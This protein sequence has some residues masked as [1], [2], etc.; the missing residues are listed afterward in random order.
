[1]NEGDGGGVEALRVWAGDA[2]RRAALL[3][4][5]E[6]GSRRPASDYDASIDELDRL[7]TL[8]DHDPALRNR[9][10]VLLGSL[11]ALR[12]AA[13]ARTGDKERAERLL[14]AA[15]EPQPGVTLAPQEEQMT[16]MMLAMLAF[17]VADLGP[18]MAGKAPSLAEIS[19][20]ALENPGG[21]DTWMT[22]LRGLVDAPE[23]L[24]SLDPEILR[25]AELFGRVE[26]EG[27]PDD[28]EELMRMVPDGHPMAGQMRELVDMMTL[29]QGDAPPADGRPAP[30]GASVVPP[31]E[32]P[33]DAPAGV[34]AGREPAAGP[35]AAAAGPGIEGPSDIALRALMPTLASMTDAMRSR[36]PHAMDEALGLLR[37]AYER[38]PPGDPLTQMLAGAM[39]GV[40]QLGQAV[41][42]NEQDRERARGLIPE[43]L[44]GLDGNL[45]PWAAP[46][47]VALRIA[48]QT[49]AVQD[50]QG[51]QDVPLLDA[52]I[53]ELTGIEAGLAPG[54]TNLPAAR[55][56]LG[57]ARM[58]R[59]LLTGDD[60]Q[61]LAG[62]DDIGA[63]AAEPELLPPPMRQLAAHLARA[64]R[65]VRAKVTGDPASI[66]ELSD[67]GPDAG[68][69]EWSSHASDLALRHEL[70]SDPVDLDG[71]ID[72]Y[73]RVR[74]ALKEGRAASLAADSLWELT[75]LHQKRWHG[76]RR[77]EDAAA[78]TETGIEAL[79]ALA[80]DVVL[81][82]GPEHGLLTARSGARRGVE[83]AKW[84]A[85]QGQL[86]QAV[87]A[88][89]LGRAT[90]LHAAAASAGV[91]ELLEGRGRPDLAAAWREPVRAGVPDGLPGE[92]PSSLRRQALEVL[93]YR[94]QGLI[95]TPTVSE[96]TAGVTASDA[97][98]LVYLMTGTGISPGLALMVGPDCGTCVIG[99]P[100]LTEHRSGPLVRYMDAAAER[101][102]RPGDQE[103]EQAWEAAL[104]TLCEWS[105]PAALGPVLS[106]MT[107]R[108][109]ANANRRPHSRTPRIVLVPCGN[110]G[111]V[112]WHAARLP[113]VAPADYACQFMAISYAASGAHFL[114][115]VARDRRPPASAAVLLADPRID[116][117]LAEQE[118]V[119]LNT[120]FYPDARLFGEYYDPDLE[121]VADGTPDELMA[122]LDE[123]LSVLHLA[124]HGSA[125]TSPTVSALHLAFPDGTQ[126]LP[127][128]RGGEGA[129]PDLG[130]LTVSRLLERASTAPPGERAEE[131]GPLVVL[132]A[133]ETDFSTRDH[134]EALTLA[135]AFVAGGARDVVGSRW[136]TQ[137]GASALMMA[138]FHHYVAVEGRSPVDAL[139]G[140]QMWM[141]DPDRRDPGTLGGELLREMDR[142][143]LDRLPLWAAFTH[144]GNP[145]PAA[146]TRGGASAARARPAG[147]PAEPEE[148][149]L[150][151]VAEHL[152]G[153][154]AALDD[155][156][157]GQLR[158]RLRSLAADPGD[159]RARRKALHGVR[160]ALLPLPL[161][162]PVRLALD[163]PR[164]TGAPTGPSGVAAA[165]EVLARM[166]GEPRQE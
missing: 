61:A 88:L 101:A 98:A 112:P 122:L 131:S 48:Q 123:P 53:E 86:P 148:Q 77:A 16:A 60:A 27:L 163:L 150:R 138:V 162:H 63:L 14:R 129:S 35:V 43:V 13:G 54:D 33:A 9:I 74:T 81:Q 69:A 107:E 115:S 151:L 157:Y 160:L 58:L 3:L 15:R 132:S 145:G 46:G 134:D 161:G 165:R 104:S 153:I 67:P 17:P 51:P 143:G 82:L 52:A 66:R 45:P 7:V 1:M 20:W 144:Q 116:L 102:A 23:A 84:A 78:A 8:L 6:G 29:L 96:L 37:A 155:A 147:E 83:T 130:M 25:V 10:T 59:G 72:A 142:P 110:L 141:L 32:V 159:P 57:Q 91:P 56:V 114:R 85:S 40:L 152:D 65:T 97:D 68:P 73:T 36:D 49:A 118:A 70:T 87:T 42:G 164:R 94:D 121:P 39:G 113:D 64:E 21:V 117:T 55:V 105:F 50:V 108:I 99:L 119:A 92:L 80:A 136:T 11:L 76:T 106:G 95:P 71:A 18:V 89:E 120:A 93:G 154:R 125:G 90:V 127:P 135:T 75:R 140:A 100:L 31:A 146:S 12:Y 126:D 139:R 79:R 158:D 109:A 22:A 4:P 38:M 149:L 166:D 34:P 137:D 47:L 111:V 28:P 124:C 103:A 5:A 24:V 41:G 133:C 128:E 26:R 2:G 44:R 156:Q 19:R 30:A 62:L